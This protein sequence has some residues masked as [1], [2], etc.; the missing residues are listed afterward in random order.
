MFQVYSI[1]TL[2]IFGS[3][4]CHLTSIGNLARSRGLSVPLVKEN[5]ED[6]RME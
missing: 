6:I 2:R 5:R 1:V 3:G 4:L